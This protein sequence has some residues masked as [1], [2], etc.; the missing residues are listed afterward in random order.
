MPFTVDSTYLWLA[1][2]VGLGI[3]EIS[4]AT[5][6]SIW[7]VAGSLFAFG[8]SF[9]TDSFILQLVTFI[10]VSG[11]SLIATRPLVKKIIGRQP[12][13]TNRD[14]LIGSVCT[15]TQDILPGKKGR[16]LVGDVGWLAQSETPLKKG[17]RAVIKDMSGATLT[18][19]PVTVTQ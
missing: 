1:L 18:V 14:M 13:A 16:V 7:F 19:E 11:A 2:A 15:V 10:V 5:L 12:V 4:T 9:L 8:V 17:S 6:V 3:L